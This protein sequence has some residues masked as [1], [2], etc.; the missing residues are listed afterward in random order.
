MKKIALMFMIVAL[1]VSA[2]ISIM[3]TL[4]GMWNVTTIKLLLTSSIV[5]GFSIPSLLCVLLLEKEKNKIIA[6][7]GMIICLF[8]CL[9]SLCVCWFDNNLLFSD[10]TSKILS[11]GTILSV[12]FGHISLLL[13]MKT[14]DALSKMVR[15]LT[16]TVASVMAFCFILMSD[17]EIDVAWQLVFILFVL[18]FVGTLLVP[19]IDK[20]KTKNTVDNNYLNNNIAD[21][22][23]QLNKLKQLLDNNIITEEEYNIEKSKI[24]NN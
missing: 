8:T 18:S 17:F 21:K 13:I 22:Y 9:Y 11:T 3:V 12:F 20:V 15:F 16:I 5:F 6:F 10:S 19:I 7:I 23:N 2:G 14:N 24:L 1:C 4:L